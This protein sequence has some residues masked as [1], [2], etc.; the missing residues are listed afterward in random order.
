[1]QDSLGSSLRCAF[2]L[3]FVLTF[4]EHRVWADHRGVCRFKINAKL[5]LISFVFLF[6]TIKGHVRLHLSPVAFW[7]C[8]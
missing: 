5:G 4:C 3:V 1:M 2:S 7:S 8:R 6:G